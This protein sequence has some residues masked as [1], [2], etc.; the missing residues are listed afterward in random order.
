MRPVQCA[1]ELV[2]RWPLEAHTYSP[3][4]VRENL[5]FFLYNAGV[6]AFV[7]GIGHYGDVVVFQVDVIWV[8]EL[9][10]LPVLVPAETE[11]GH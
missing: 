5:V 4:I 9:Q 3:R 8:R 7:D 6:C 2:L 10:Q 11:V 1:E